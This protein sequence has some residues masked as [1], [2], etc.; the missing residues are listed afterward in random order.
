VTLTHKEQFLT[1][2]QPYKIALELE[3]PES[4]ANQNLGM[5]MACGYLKNKDGNQISK[6]CRSAMFPYRSNILHA[7]ATFVF[8]P[9][10]LAGSSEQKQK[11]EIELFSNYME[12]RLSP[13]TDAYIQIES[14]KI[15]I[16]RSSLRII[17][18]FTGLRHFM[19]HWPLPSAVVGIVINMFFLTIIAFLSWYKYFSPVQ[20]IVQVAG[21]DKTKAKDLEERRKHRE[22]NKIKL[23]RMQQSRMQE[24][25]K[26]TCKEDLAGEAVEEEC[27]KS[28]CSENNSSE[29]DESDE[30]IEV[31]GKNSAP[32]QC[33]SDEFEVLLS[34]ATEEKDQLIEDDKEN[35][36]QPEV[37]DPESHVRNRLARTGS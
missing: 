30:S 12:Q 21:Y 17:A 36:P 26:S 34:K 31:T 37:E 10:L 25:S 13:T 33:S 7:I 23:I 9:F 1:V 4:P 27:S 18:Q 14:H 2:G 5:F 15:E 19:F 29:R 8:S 3:M 35:R 22:S 32:H 20:N 28:S 6:S 16:Y 11:I 24:T